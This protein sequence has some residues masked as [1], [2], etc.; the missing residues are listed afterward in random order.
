L[1]SETTVA[2]AELSEWPA[3][4]LFSWLLAK[5][6][7]PKQLNSTLQTES[8]ANERPDS[9]FCNSHDRFP[10]YTWFWKRPVCPD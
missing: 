2:V 8:R 4:G 5:K 1:F 10:L 7:S 3:N 6:G 9:A